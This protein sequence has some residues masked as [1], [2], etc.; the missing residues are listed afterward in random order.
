M[1]KIEEY[2]QRH[3]DTYSDLGSLCGDA[4]ARQYYRFRADGQ[5]YI[6]VV[7]EPLSQQI[8]DFIKVDKLLAS[9]LNRPKILHFNLNESYLIQNDLG[10]KHLYD[11][12]KDKSNYLK[13]LLGDLKYYNGIDINSFPFKDKKFDSNKLNFEFN[14]AMQY[15]VGKYLNIS[16]DEKKSKNINSKFIEVFSKK[17]TICHRD[18]HSKNILIKDETLFH[19][20]FQDSMI[21]PFLY[22][23]CSLIEDPYGSYSNKDELK[24]YFFEIQENYKSRDEFES[25]YFYISLQR[26]FKALGSFTFL[27]YE[28][29]KSNYLKYIP[30]TLNGIKEILSSGKDE[31][32]IQFFHKIIE[33]YDERFK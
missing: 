18:Y 9:E 1:K 11:V 26:L 13:S 5:S 8:N 25:D 21:G 3:F 22:D 16:V 24:N 19:I 15:F 14:L 31:E 17:L 23:V 10:D 30:A 12:T 20:D 33:S 2:I 4:S 7:D 29:N 6:I 27:N 28:K 32:T